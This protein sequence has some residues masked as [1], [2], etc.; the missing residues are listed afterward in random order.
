MNAIVW[1][2]PARE[3]QLLAWLAPLAAPHG[4]RPETLQL[5][6]ED[7]STR[8]YLRLQTAAGGSLI[9][10]DAPPQH[11]SQRAF[12]EIA[13]HMADCGLRVP[14]VLAADE[15]LG[16]LL[17][18]DFG[19]RPY[20]QALQQAS[21]AEADALMRAAIATLLQ[22]Q[23]KGDAQRLPAF[24]ESFV[25]R[26][27]QIFS[28]WCVEREF[29]QQ[30]NATQ[31]GWWAHSCQV[32]VDNIL[33]QPQLA[34]HRDFMP[35]N[36]MVIEGGPGVLDFQDAVRGPI[37]YDLASLL[38]DTFISWDEER[39]LDWAIRYWEQARKAGLPVDA[40]FGEFW[41]QLEWTGL[42]RHLKILGLFCRLKQRDG[43]P[44]YAEDLP[45]FF[46]YAIKVSTRYVQ[47]SPL[48]HLLEGLR[49]NLVQTGFS[50]R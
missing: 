43:K 1:P 45:R 33:S 18:S 26:E 12:I 39:E 38:R 7:A 24:D 28:D 20:L 36:L 29:G 21:D 44:A 47:L 22:W 49:G 16:F 23:L 19:D 13:A 35:R 5:A 9:V 6:K 41:R 15:G 10:M 14:T 3:Q 37:S 50:L 25:R 42:Q 32:L 34:M 31:Q 4:L 48:T 8:R 27:L 46:A 2:D 17:L 11:G 40:D 30:W